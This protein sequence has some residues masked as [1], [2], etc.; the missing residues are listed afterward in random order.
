M[1]VPTAV[2]STRPGAQPKPIQG[3][4]HGN[5]LPYIIHREKHC[6][7]EVTYVAVLY[8]K[9]LSVNVKNV[10]CRNHDIGFVFY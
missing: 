10:K 1:G 9:V 6:N 3:L 5:T 8:R 2:L 7:N 4:N